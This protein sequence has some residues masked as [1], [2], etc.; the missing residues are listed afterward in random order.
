MHAGG[1]TLVEVTPVMGDSRTRAARPCLRQTG[2]NVIMGWVA[3]RC[4]TAGTGA[5]EHRRA[6]DLMVGEVERGGHRRVR[7]GVLGEIGTGDPLLPAEERVLRRRRAYLRTGCPINAHGGRLPSG[8]GRARRVGG[9]G[10]AD[11]GRAVI[12]HMDVAIDL[13]S[14]ARVAARGRWWS[15]T[16]SATSTTRTAAAIACPATP[17]AAVGDRHARRRGSDR[18]DPDLAGRLPAVAVEALRRR[19]VTPD[20]S[21]PCAAAAIGITAAQWDTLVR[22]NPHG[23]SP[24]SR[25]PR[26]T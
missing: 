21:A 11:F 7:P 14:N 13:P 18:V 19:N 22:D 10:L 23:C 12:S 15:T 4:R 26:S 5:A 24:T 20:C 9:R 8:D 25:P 2:A 3:R 1:S 6:A 16:P 17:T